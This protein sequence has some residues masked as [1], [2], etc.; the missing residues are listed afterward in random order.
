[1]LVSE[2][3]WCTNRFMNRVDTCTCIRTYFQCDYGART[4]ASR[5]FT[6]KFAVI[7]REETDKEY[8]Q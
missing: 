8:E 3:W 7:T 1:M 6:Y 5:Y 4:N 2:I